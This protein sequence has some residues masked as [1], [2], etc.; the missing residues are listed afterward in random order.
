[1]MGLGGMVVNKGSVKVPSWDRR[2]R[3][4]ASRRAGLHG[5]L[6]GATWG[7]ASNLDPLTR[8]GADTV[9]LGADR[10]ADAVEGVSGVVAER[11]RRTGTRW[12][13]SLGGPGKVAEKKKG[14]VHVEDTPS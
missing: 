6:L 13:D 8:A 11:I 9:E 1:M 14:R 3:L 2:T 7:V 12:A 10:V 5:V 4:R